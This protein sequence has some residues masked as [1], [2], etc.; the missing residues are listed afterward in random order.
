MI[1]WKSRF[2]RWILGGGEGNVDERNLGVGHVVRVHREKVTD[3]SVQVR[4][5]T[6]GGRLDSIGLNS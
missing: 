5:E 2:P 1:T 4:A 3:T 6:M